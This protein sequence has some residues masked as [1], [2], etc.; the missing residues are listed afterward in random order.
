VGVPTPTQSFQWL[1]FQWVCPELAL[2]QASLSLLAMGWIVP[3]VKL[4]YGLF[5][6]VEWL[7]GDADLAQQ[8]RDANLCPPMAYDHLNMGVVDSPHPVWWYMG[9][10][11]NDHFW[12]T[13]NTLILKDGSRQCRRCNRQR[14]ANRRKK[15]TL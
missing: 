6:A 12:S 10:C 9:M 13:K 8:A 4:S 11:K 5:A 2:C 7:M 15:S 14:Q 3:P 1:R